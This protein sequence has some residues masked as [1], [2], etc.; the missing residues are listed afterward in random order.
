MVEKRAFRNSDREP[1]EGSKSENARTKTRKNREGKGRKKNKKKRNGTKP[2]ETK[3]NWKLIK[4][5]LISPHRSIS[6]NIMK[7]FDHNNHHTTATTVQ[8][9]PKWKVML[10]Q[11]RFDRYNRNNHISQSHRSV[12]LQWHVM[13]RKLASTISMFMF[14]W[15]ITTRVP[16]QVQVTSKAIRWCWLLTSED[17]VTQIQNKS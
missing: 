15:T 7:M 1:T 14:Y 2:N 13:H 10:Q 17:N 6:H 4:T 5:H 11:W 8:N 3:R 9:L 16:V 12:K